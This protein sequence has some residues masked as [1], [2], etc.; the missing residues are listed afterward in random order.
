MKN[1]FKN[2]LLKSVTILLSGS[3]IAQLL[4][5]LCSPIMTRLYTE[6]QI[7]EYTL[8]LTA[9]SMFGTVLCGRYDQSIVSES[10]ERRVYALVKLC[11]ILSVVTSLAIGV[12]YT[13]Y[14]VY[15]GETTLPW[16]EVFL[17]ITVLLVLTGVGYAISAYNNRFKQYKLMASVHVVR[18]VGKEVSMIGLGAL[19]TGARGLL[20]SQV[21]S[22]GL[23]LN[24]QARD[25]KQNAQK[26]RSVT[27]ADIKEAAKVH[28]RQP[29]FSVPASFA[30]NYSYSVLNLFINELYG[31][32]TLAHYSMSFRILGLPL[33]LISVNVSKAFFEKASREYD[34]TGKC[35]KTFLQT[36]GMLLVV[37][38]PMVALLM[39]LA[40]WAFEWFFG[41]GWGQAGVYVQCL[42]PLFGLRLVV[43]T[44]APTMIICGKQAVELILQGSFFLCAYVARFLCGGR[45]TEEFLICVAAL[46]AVVYVVF[47]LIMLK[48]SNS[49]QK[50][51]KQDG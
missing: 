12:G 26:L 44:L 28:I 11:L 36:S 9:I 34:E 18:T 24:R 15:N 4:S 13:A 23:G 6:E 7:G 1:P 48:A 50:E 8:L 14:F 16:W 22:V 27:A 40:P 3:V 46:Y 2:S 33:G 47:Y 41:E 51:K 31:A 30:N 42:A 20:V 49:T 21:L 19:K 38:I 25:L 45:S 35:R 43:G 39:L 10:N 37:A 32:A 17:W 5:I 29:L